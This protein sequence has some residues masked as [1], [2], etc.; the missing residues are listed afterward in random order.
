MGGVARTVGAELPHVLV[1]RSEKCLI[2]CF[3]LCSALRH[4]SITPSDSKY[5][6]IFIILTLMERYLN[7]IH[8]N[9]ENNDVIIDCIMHIA[10]V[11]SDFSCLF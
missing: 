11:N 7:E 1:I 6:S 4:A 5:W 8:H 3:P 2:I 10:C 9:Y